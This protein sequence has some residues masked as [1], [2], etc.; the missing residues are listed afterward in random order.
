MAENASAETAVLAGWS[1]GSGGG[2]VAIWI[3]REGA[4]CSFDKYETR[5]AHSWRVGRRVSI[6]RRRTAPCSLASLV[7]LDSYDDSL[8]RAAEAA[9]R[10]LGPH[11]TRIGR[12]PPR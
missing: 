6:E 11:A 3:G 8:V 12:K 1:A 5:G 9:Q 2:E 10:F 4:V 7:L